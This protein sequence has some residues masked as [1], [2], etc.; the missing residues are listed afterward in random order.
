[1]KQRIYRLFAELNP[2]LPLPLTGE[3]LRRT[4]AIEILE[5]IPKPAARDLLQAWSE[6]TANAYLAAEARRALE[7]LQ[8]PLR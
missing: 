4:R 1:M 2:T 5:R 7:N 6:Q 3:N 8:M